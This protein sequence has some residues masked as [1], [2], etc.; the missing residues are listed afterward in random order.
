MRVDNGDVAKHKETIIW[1]LACDC[2]NNNSH[3]IK[4][5]NV[6]KKNKE[7][8]MIWYLFVFI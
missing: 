2:F 4:K 5:C 3:F 6:Q 1:N 8:E 7:T